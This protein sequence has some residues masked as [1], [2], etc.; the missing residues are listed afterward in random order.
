MLRSAAVSRIRLSLIVLGCAV[1]GTSLAIWAQSSRGSEDGHLWS[2]AA[3]SPASGDETAEIWRASAS[4]ERPYFIRAVLRTKAALKAYYN[5]APQ[6]V[7]AWR[8]QPNFREALASSAG[9]QRISDSTRYSQSARRRDIAAMEYDATLHVQYAEWFAT[10]S[11]LEIQE[12]QWEQRLRDVA[13]QRMIL[14][15]AT[16]RNF[17]AYGGADVGQPAAK[18]DFEHYV[19]FLLGLGGFPAAEEDAITASCVTIMPVMVSAGAITIANIWRWPVDHVAAVS[20]GLELVLIGLLFVPLSIWIGTGD[21]RLAMRHLGG[22]A[23]KLL[24]LAPKLLRHIG[25][26][27]R[28]FLAIARALARHGGRGARRLPALARSAQRYL[29][30]AAGRMLAFAQSL[31]RRKFV[32]QLE[33]WWRAV[34]ADTRRSV[35]TA[36]DLAGARLWRRDDTTAGASF[37][38][39]ERDQAI[40]GASLPLAAEGRGYGMPTAQKNPGDFLSHEP[41]LGRARQRSG[42]ASELD[43]VFATLSADL[44]KLWSSACMEAIE[45][46][47]RD[48]ARFPLLDVPPAAA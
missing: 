26:E 14:G 22:E 24:A 39:I 40:K 1:L 23:R 16:R 34:F 42:R 15:E 4:C 25:G 28:R 20:F 11:K 48:N 9:Y 31:P 36:M 2:N 12:S 8:E 13:D 29:S 35:L 3:S 5:A 10:V 38:E 27:A 45:T 32:L 6:Q 47:D 46:I 7:R 44:M 21:F 37:A 43:E 33:A 41:A 18:R 30:G 17:K 19:L